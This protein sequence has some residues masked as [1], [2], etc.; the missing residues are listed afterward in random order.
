M[1]FWQGDQK[2]QE[3]VLKNPGRYLVPR[4]DWRFE[5][6]ILDVL[7]SD[8]E[9]IP[10]ELRKIVAKYANPPIQDMTPPEAPLE[11]CPPRLKKELGHQ[12]STVGI[13]F[14]V[15]PTA[16]MNQ[17]LL[18]AFVQPP[19]DSPYGQGIFEIKIYV[20][21]IYPFTRP[22]YTFETPVYHPFFSTVS[23]TLCNI[24]TSSAASIF[25]DLLMLQSI[26]S[27]LPDPSLIPVTDNMNECSQLAI[28][29]PEEFARCA[30]FHTLQYA[31]D[32]LL[33]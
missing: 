21:T 31:C 7:T 33:Q 22:T 19:P 25:T 24:N 9:C 5:A 20:P 11:F 4:P 1:E 10:P 14:G 13:L 16:Q 3:I 27:V 28:L 15:Y 17:R 6:K 30:R 23:N 32:H 8:L 2:L 12:E 29:A 26:L 18:K